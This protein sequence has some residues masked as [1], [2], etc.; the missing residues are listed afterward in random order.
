MSS[1]STD[2]PVAAKV[3][4][5][6]LTHYIRANERAERWSRTMSIRQIVTP[7]ASSTAN[8][9]KEIVH[10]S[11][12]SSRRMV[13]WSVECAAVG[14]VM[15]HDCVTADPDIRGGRLV[16]LGTGFT[17]AQ[18]LAELASSNGVEE[19]ADEFDLDPEIIRK[20]LSGMSLLFERSWSK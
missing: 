7:S 3:S 18:T 14:S 8:W 16:L 10:S 2:F 4:G 19:V 5:V 17:I 11:S 12:Q 20:F 13:E 9:A 15:M 1:K 6:A